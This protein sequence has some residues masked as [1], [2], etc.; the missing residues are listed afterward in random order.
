[1]K[2]NNDAKAVL[3]EQTYR[4]K[5]AK[6]DEFKPNFDDLLKKK[7][8]EALQKVSQDFEELFVGMVL[9]T[10]RKS[11]MK[12]EFSKSSHELELYEGM[13]DEAYAKSIAEKGSFGIAKMLMESFEPYLKEEGEKKSGFDLKG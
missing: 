3:L 7:D 9:K 6:L 2:I 12:S 5:D 1:M 10:M 8:R 11:V 4:S 13:L